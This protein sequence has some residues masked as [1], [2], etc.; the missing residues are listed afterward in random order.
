MAGNEYCEV[1]QA[2]NI[3]KDDGWRVGVF[4]YGIHL[5]TMSLGGTLMC[6][7]VIVRV[8]G[9]SSRGAVSVQSVTIGSGVLRTAW[10]N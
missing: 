2:R 9:V 4:C 7:V 3:V 10:Q 1:S 6:Y 5:P 8:G